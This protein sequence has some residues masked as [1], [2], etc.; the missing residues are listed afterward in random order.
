M[1]KT[2]YE[3]RIT[4]HDDLQIMEVDF[5][6]VTFEDARQVNDFYDVIDEKIAATGRDWYFLVNYFNCQ[7]TQWAW[8]PFARRGKLVNLA[9]SMGTARLRRRR[10]NGQDDPRKVRTGIVRRQS[11]RHP[12]ECNGENR[13]DETSRAMNLS[14]GCWDRANPCIVIAEAH[15][16]YRTALAETFRQQIRSRSYSAGGQP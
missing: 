2:D 6:N 4:F 8:L 10:G 1:E 12:R 16:L 5:S 13:R 15:P 3:K 14:V 11:V 7:L 9:H